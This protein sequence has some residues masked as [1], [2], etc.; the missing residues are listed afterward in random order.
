MIWDQETIKAT[1]EHYHRYG[2]TNLFVMVYAAMPPEIQAIV[3]Y[4]I[5]NR[6]ITFWREK[7]E[8]SGKDVAT[9]E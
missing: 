1:A 6:R 3:A 7:E 4:K 2:R 9:W 8:L 5:E